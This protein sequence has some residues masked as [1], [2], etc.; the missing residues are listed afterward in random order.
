MADKISEPNGDKAMINEAELTDLECL[1]L[2]KMKPTVDRGKVDAGE[3]EVD[4]TIRVFGTVK[5]SEDNESI[6]A[7]AVPWE[8]VGLIALSKLSAASRNKILREALGDEDVSNEIKE[9]AIAVAD[10]LKGKTRKMKNGQV[11]T[12]I[13]IEAA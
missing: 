9:E 6:I 11:R 5:V 10:T 4:F 13:V 8:R 2:D 7:A 1:A 12:E 3:H